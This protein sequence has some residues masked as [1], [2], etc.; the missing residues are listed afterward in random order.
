MIGKL[1][2]FTT[3]LARQHAWTEVRSSPGVKGVSQCLLNVLKTSVGLTGVGICALPVKAVPEKPSQG[4]PEVNPNNLTSGTLIKNAASMA[5]DSSSTLLTQTFVAVMEKYKEL[6]QDI[7]NLME[8]LQR[9]RHLKKLGYET[10]D[11]WQEVVEAR[12]HI[13]DRRHEIQDLEAILNSALL[14]LEAASEAAFQAG[15]EELAMMGRDRCHYA[16]NQ[17][18]MTRAVIKQS[19]DALV[20]LQADAIREAETDDG[21]KEAKS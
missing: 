3:H 2:V 15:N 21:E 19:E 18:A 7:E 4:L 6:A 20:R 9:H 10:Q 12:V 13:D 11:V 5:V 16:N 14:A 17:L 1:R 8:L